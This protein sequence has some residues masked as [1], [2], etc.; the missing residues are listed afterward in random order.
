MKMFKR[1]FKR[2][3]T[4]E[5]QFVQSKNCQLIKYLSTPI[6]ETIEHVELGFPEPILYYLKKNANPKLL[7]KLMKSSKLHFSFKDFPFFEI[8]F[9]KIDKTTWKYYDRK[10]DEIKDLDLNSLSKPLWISN[11]I[12]CCTEQQK[13][14][15]EE[16]LS[17]T[18]ICDIRYF[19]IVGRNITLNQL[20]FIN[21]KKNIENF[22]LFNSHITC[23]CGIV[24]IDRIVKCLPNVKTFLWFFTPTMILTINS[25]TTKKLIEA[26]N[27]TK[28]QSFSLMN[29][30]ETFD[31]ILFKKFMKANPSIDFYLEFNNISLK[32]SKILQ[33]FVDKLI[34]TASKTY[35]PIRISFPNQTEES[36]QSMN[37]LYQ[38]HSQKIF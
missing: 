38:I 1:I 10:S 23:C 20:K 14:F 26:L 7:L 28:L 8:H 17:K 22:T 24:S 33:N 2:T 11:G 30:P 36:R 29:I 5:S 9:I 15:V 25:V 27:P 12:E 4:S 21:S 32:F 35:R 31:F 34:K 3:S 37:A 18:F 13:P 19:R 16:L 6:K